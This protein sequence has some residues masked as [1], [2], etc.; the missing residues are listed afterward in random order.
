MVRKKV[1]GDE[2]QRRAAA[3]EAR[4]EGQAPS[5][6]GQTTGASK[7]RAHLPGHGSVPHEDKLASGGRAKQGE[8]VSA[9]SAAPRA[10]QPG[11]DYTGRG[12][13]PYTEQHERVFQAVTEAGQERGGD[14]AH[15]QEV[16]RAA[17]LPPGETRD[18]LHDLVTV[19]R[20]VT[21]LAGADSPDLGPR[22][23]AKPRL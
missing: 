13:P 10:G 19:H 23:E 21:E 20:L 4:R 7:Q 1:E 22:Y 6:R 11:H 3:R 15:L 9:A 8:P 16:A 17:G 5:A 2:A 18:L 14:G 12:Q